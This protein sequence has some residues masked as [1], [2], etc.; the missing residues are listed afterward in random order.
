MRVE[1]GELDVGADQGRMA[2][3][4]RREDRPGE[5]RQAARRGSR[6]AQA[7]DCAPEVDR[8]LQAMAVQEI[9]IRA[10]PGR[11]APGRPGVTRLTK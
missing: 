8:F 1:Q 2:D 10:D 3:E 7:G 11:S 6:C 5:P 9:S 4:Q